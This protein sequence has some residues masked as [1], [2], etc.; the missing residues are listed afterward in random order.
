[1]NP[2]HVTGDST[3]NTLQVSE[4]DTKNLSTLENHPECQVHS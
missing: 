2:H 3:I 1:V 4:R